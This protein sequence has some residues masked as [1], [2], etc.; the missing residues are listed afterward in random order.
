VNSFNPQDY[1]ICLTTPALL[2]GSAWIQHVPFGMFLIDLLRPATLVELGTLYGVSYCAFCQA[3]AELQM[4]TK[5]YGID[6]W[7]GDANID[8]IEHYAFAEL[9][10]YHDPLYGSF[11]KLLRC[12][13]ND[14]LV[15]FADGTVDLLHIDGFHAYDAVKE[16][17][18]SWLPKMS[19]R[20]V[21]LFHDIAVNKSGFGVWKLWDELKTVYPHFEMHHGFGLGVLAV[22]KEYPAPLKM[23]TEARNDESEA[24]STL[25]S[26]LGMGIEAM[27]DLK[28]EREL[29]A[30]SRAL[31]LAQTLTHP[32]RI[33]GR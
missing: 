32:L 26:R 25:F 1:P 15:T 7:E 23:L 18:E 21:V 28:L 8:G 20:G 13:F 11:S 2:G 10:S 27:R 3:V 6:T 29:Y 16:D 17:F 9:S 22:G 4:D 33:F 30:N 24:I 14:A 19:R 31:K 5:C 12:T